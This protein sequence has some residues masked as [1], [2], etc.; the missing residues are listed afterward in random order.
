[1]TTDGLSATSTDSTTGTGVDSRAVHLLN[2]MK[3]N[4]VEILILTLI[5]QQLGWLTTA[6]TSLQGVCF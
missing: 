6:T 5:A 4:K 3:E 2:M 1:M